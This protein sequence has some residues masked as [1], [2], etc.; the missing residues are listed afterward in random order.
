MGASQVSAF[1]KLEEA[2]QVFINERAHEDGGGSGGVVVDFFVAVG[3]TRID[4]DGEQPFARTYASGSNP[5]GSVGVAEVALGDMRR[6]LNGGDDD[7]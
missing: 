3:Y 2:I 4:E 1:S 7:G 5:F 6:D